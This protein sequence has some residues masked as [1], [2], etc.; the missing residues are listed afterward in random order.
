MKMLQIICFC[1]TIG[2]LSRPL[3]TLKVSFKLC[4]TQI[5]FHSHIR[6][7]F[8]PYYIQINIHSSKIES[9]DRQNSLIRYN[10]TIRDNIQI[11]LYLKLGKIIKAAKLFPKT[12]LVTLY[13]K[14]IN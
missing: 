4:H 5:N 14:V 7:I 6:N 10:D 2:T 13:K 1:L 11:Y 12:F 3:C 8:T 9:Q